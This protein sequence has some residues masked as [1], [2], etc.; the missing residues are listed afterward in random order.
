MI[1]FRKRVTFI[2][3]ENGSG[4]STFI[5]AFA[6]CCGFNTVGGSRARNISV[7][8]DNEYND[9]EIFYKYLNID[10]SWEFS[11]SDGYFIRSETLYDLATKIEELEP[12]YEIKSD[13]GKIPL[14]K[15]S[16]GES[17]LSLLTNRI[18]KRGLYI[19][20]EPETGLSPKNLFAMLTRINDLVKMQ[21]Q[22]IISTHP[23]ILLAFPDCEIYE[24]KNG[25]LQL[26]CYEE[27]D[28]YNLTKYFLLNYKTMLTNLGVT[29]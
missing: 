9:N 23:P 13:Y 25:K 22:F 28:Y 15:Q 11:V 17:V 14:H 4:K 26:I 6:R 21:S 1:I 19:F 5:E 12:G 29:V 7:Y 24:I 27:T 3:G 10:K 16:H 18:C 20:D 2:I 8:K